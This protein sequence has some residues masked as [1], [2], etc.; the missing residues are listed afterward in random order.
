MDH[1]STRRRI[2][3]DNLPRFVRDLGQFGKLQL[4]IFLRQL[5]QNRLRLTINMMLRV[6]PWL[7]AAGVDIYAHIEIF[8]QL[9]NNRLGVVHLRH[10]MASGNGILP[11]QHWHILII[12]H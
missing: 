2:D 6:P 1:D 8:R 7:T 9:N 10:R 4:I 12:S 5:L 11:N 3:I